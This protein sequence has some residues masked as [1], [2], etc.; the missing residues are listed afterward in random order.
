MTVRKY[1][2]I[3]ANYIY[4]PGNA[5]V[6]NG[7]IVIEENRIIEV[8][9]TEGKIYETEGLEFY[10]GLIVPDY[11][12]KYAGTL[13]EGDRLTVALDRC[14]ETE[15]GGAFGPAIIEGADLR[16][17]VWRQGAAVRKL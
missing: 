7:Y 8:K 16:S 13:Q 11:F 1:R 3:A 6:K 2:K 5:L 10:G 15:E 17:M 14:Y 4:L 12:L 9:D